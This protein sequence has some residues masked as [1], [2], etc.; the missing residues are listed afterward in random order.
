M[1]HLA[2]TFA[3]T[4]LATLPARAADRAAL[5]A[6]VAATETAFAQTMADRDLAA[7]SRFV[8]GEAVFFTGP[9]PLRGKSAIVAYWQRWYTEKQPPFSWR[10]EKLEVLDSGT[11]ALSTGP[12]FDKNGK[13]VSSY[14]SIWRLE[15][16]GT[17]RIVFDKGCGCAD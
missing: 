6:E 10:P 12:V 8:S 15:A 13:R 3:L 11:L 5:E 16:P 1:R 9:A 14:T 7:F 4:A 2:L 17:W